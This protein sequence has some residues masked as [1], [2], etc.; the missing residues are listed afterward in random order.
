[1]GI[2]DRVREKSCLQKTFF[3]H[4]REYY[5][6]QENGTSNAFNTT[7]QD[8]SIDSEAAVQSKIVLK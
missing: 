6:F 4:I 5:D 8:Y 3:V 7:R 1:M 2:E